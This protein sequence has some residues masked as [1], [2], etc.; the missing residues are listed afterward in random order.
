MRIGICSENRRRGFRGHL[1]YDQAFYLS[2]LFDEMEHD[3]RP[4]LRLRPPGSAAASLAFKPDIKDR[5]DERAQAS[6]D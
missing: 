4:E 3:L 1:A 5:P 6:H 2:A